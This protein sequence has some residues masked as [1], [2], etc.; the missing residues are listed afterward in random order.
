M[1]TSK[2]FCV[3]IILTV[4]ALGAAVFLQVHEMLQYDLVNTLQERYFPSS[5]KADTE[6]DKAAETAQKP[7]TPPA[8]KTSSQPAVPAD[9]AGKKN[10]KK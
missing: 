10:E 8:G 5:P 2:T 3:I 9:K 1:F 7:E 6:K 4:F